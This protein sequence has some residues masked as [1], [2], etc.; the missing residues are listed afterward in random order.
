MPEYVWDFICGECE[1]GK[2]MF[3][4]G[5]LIVKNG[6]PSWKPFKKGGEE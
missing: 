4:D 1:D 5:L 3:P 2:Y 6:Y